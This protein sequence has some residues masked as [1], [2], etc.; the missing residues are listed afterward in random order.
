MRIARLEAAQQVGDVERDL[1]DLAVVEA[2]PPLRQ[3]DADQQALAEARRRQRRQ[4]LRRQLVRHLLRLLLGERLDAERR[5]QLAAALAGRQLALLQHAEAAQRAV[6]AQQQRVG[7]VA[8]D[9]RQRHRLAGAPDVLEARAERV[10]DRRLGRPHQPA[11]RALVVVQQRDAAAH[12]LDPEARQPPAL[13]DVAAQAARV[14]ARDPPLGA[15]QQHSVAVRR[16]RRARQREVDVGGEVV[17]DP[18][19]VEEPQERRGGR[20][21][22]V[23][24]RARQ[25]ARPAHRGAVRERVEHAV[26]L[27]VDKLRPAP[28]RDREHDQ[29]PG[30]FARLHGHRHARLVAAGEE[31]EQVQAGVVVRG[32][33]LDR[34]V[35]GRA[36]AH[37]RPPDADAAHPPPVRP[38]A[39]VDVHADP[40]GRRS[41]AGP[42]SRRRSRARRASGSLAL[43]RARPAPRPAWCRRCARGRARSPGSCRC[44]SEPACRR[45]GRPTPACASRAPAGGSRRRVPARRRPGRPSPASR[46]GWR[47][48]RR[49]SGSGP[50]RGRRSGRARCA[51]RAGAAAGC[52][53]ASCAAPPPS[54]PGGAA[55]PGSGSG[56]R[57][58]ARRRPCGRPTPAAAGGQGRRWRR[59]RAGARSRRRSPPR[60]PRSRCARAARPRSG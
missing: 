13:G 8:A 48:S 23:R 9:Q 16:P 20:V 32:P 6:E 37:H 34:L 45:R 35:R 12:A 27:L 36:P 30:P 54:A 19:A 15:R 2:L 51:S 24:Q 18:G 43:G 5:E 49:R 11:G 42:A 57:A 1:S 7:G 52:R 25:H 31:L 17:A 39:R 58:R 14:G 28:G 10:L 53:P 40:L 21:E 33:E 26:V 60:R 55:S 29:H 3:A 46:A 56:R 50:C 59:P 44:R 4:R 47:P 41:P 22:V 38:P